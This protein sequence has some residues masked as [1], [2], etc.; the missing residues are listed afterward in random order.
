MHLSGIK[1]CDL[2]L[3]PNFWGEEMPFGPMTIGT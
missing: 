1:P 2:T 3:H